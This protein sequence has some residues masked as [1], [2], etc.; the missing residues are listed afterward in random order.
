[1]ATPQFFEH[2][3]YLHTRVP[4]I[5]RED[6]K[7][8][9][10]SPPWSG[11]MSGFTLLFE[12]RLLQLCR[13]MPVHNVSQLTR[14]SD[15]KIWRMLDSYIDKARSVDDLSDVKAVGMDETSVARGHDYITLFVDLEE[16]KTIDI[17]D[18]KGS[19]T[20]T[21]FVDTLENK[22]GARINIQDISC[23]MSPAF[24]KGVKERLPEAAITFD[25]FHILKIINKGV[26][27][28]RRAEAKENPLL[29]GSR[30]IFLKNDLNLTEKQKN[31]KNALSLP[32]LNLKSVRAMTIGESF[33]QIYTA[34][35]VQD[36]ES[37]LSQ[38]YNWATHS[39]LPPMVKAA[40]TIK[41]HWEGVIR[42]QESQINNGIL[43]GLNPVLQAAKRK[44]RGYKKKHFKTI[45]YLLTGKLSFTQFNE[46][47][48]PT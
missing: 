34:N 12:A 33:Q 23:D 29:K 1:M 3:C 21:H 47:C 13:S 35:T 19:E 39:Q 26:D 17:S 22:G 28:V 41:R 9:L 10:I 27:D 16:R 8:C 11:V 40:K 32:S 5:K 14:V 31:M 30:Y 4:R 20:L 6:G 36:F 7:V 25:K 42:W 43:E 2:E 15:Y 18:G 37:L 45:A 38:C 44:V 24:I 48:V 46:N